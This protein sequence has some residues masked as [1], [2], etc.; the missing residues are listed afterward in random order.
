MLIIVTI[1]GRSVKEPDE[2][3]LNMSE[4]SKPKEAM[5]EQSRGRAP[6]EGESF[7]LEATEG[8]FLVKPWGW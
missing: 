5:S 1:V 2:K 3:T 6:G 7:R 8:G 4:S